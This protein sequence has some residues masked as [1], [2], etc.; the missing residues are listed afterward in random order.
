MAAQR[1]ANSGKKRKQRSNGTICIS[2]W[3]NNEYKSKNQEGRRQ[4]KTLIEA[5]AEEDKHWNSVVP[6]GP[7]C[8]MWPCLSWSRP[9]LFFFFLGLPGPFIHP[10]PSVSF[11]P[12]FP[13]AEIPHRSHSNVRLSHGA[14]FLI[15]TQ[16]QSETPAPPYPPNTQK[17]GRAL[18]VPLRPW[19]K[20]KKSVDLSADV[21]R[22]RIVI[23]LSAQNQSESK[24]PSW[25]R[26]VFTKGV[27]ACFYALNKMLNCQE[28]YNK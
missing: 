7:P 13:E 5:S 12:S 26:G 8:S 4:G 10:I 18:T 22:Q 3:F 28:I 15:L 2:L 21:R 27:N 23:S 16:H 20:K 1:K 9:E 17:C 19:K 11:F 6:S 14:P 25:V 24:I